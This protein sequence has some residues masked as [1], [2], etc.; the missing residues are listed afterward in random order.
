MQREIF[1][2]RDTTLNWCRKKNCCL[3]KT[4]FNAIFVTLKLPLK[5]LT[6][7]LLVVLGAENEHNTMFQSQKKIC[8]SDFEQVGTKNNFFLII[9]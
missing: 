8:R 3:K 4:Q 5:T 1:I 7:M 6:V 9:E 2:S